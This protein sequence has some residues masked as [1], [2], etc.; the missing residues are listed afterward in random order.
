MPNARLHRAPFPTLPRALRLA[1]LALLTCAAV[2]VA[3]LAT[4]VFPAPDKHI[5]ANQPV[6]I[7]ADTAAAPGLF[8]NISSCDSHLS[9]HTE[10]IT[11]NDGIRITKRQPGLVHIGDT[12]GQSAMIARCFAFSD[13]ETR[14]FLSGSGLDQQA[15]D[16][17]FATIYARLANS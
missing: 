16:R 14:L 4:G 12:N 17:I 9:R 11:G 7:F 10:T 2:L 8:A 15:V 5:R 3:V 6:R 1:K 13:N